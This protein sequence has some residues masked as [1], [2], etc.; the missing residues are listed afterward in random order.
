MTSGSVDVAIVGG[1]VV[2]LSIAYLLA[3]EG[4]GVRVVDRGPIGRESSWA[5]AGIISP[6]AERPTLLPAAK[7]RT[8]SARLH[9]EWSK[10]LLAETGIDNGYRRT[11][12]IDVAL[13][14]QDVSDLTSAAGRW[15]DE[16]IAFERLGPNDL[17]RVEPALG[18]IV[19]SAY[20]LPD[21]AQL[22]NPWHLRA[23]TEAIRIK[24]GMVAG[25]CGVESFEIRGDRILGL[26]TVQQSIACGSVV[27]A[28]GAWSG[29]L[30][31]GLGVTIAT[32]PVRGQIVLL[33]PGRPILRRIVEHGKRYLIPRDEG[34]ILIGSTEEDVGF[35]NETTPE[36]ISGLLA[37]AR[38]ICPVLEGIE[39]ERSWAGLRPGS[40][41]TRPYLGPAPGFSN[42]FVATGHNR[43]GLQLSTGSASI[44]ADLVLGRTPRID[45]RAFRV[46]RTGSSDR[47]DAFRS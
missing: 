14:D 24:G 8:L 30:L 10:R 29:G 43:A 20:F 11:G 41:D 4:V 39:P 27:I 42:A 5:G 7:L 18:P 3:S 1:G 17:V 38:S 2:G 33:N 6:G 46:D 25:E 16:G 32:P 26:R 9:P 35:V 21:R 44:M 34:R 13:N 47:A 19:K 23:L 15:R 36:G 28:A 31:S 40:I 45:P 12:G 22:R 37:F